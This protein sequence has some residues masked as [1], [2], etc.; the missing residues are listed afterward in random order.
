[1]EVAS[2]LFIYFLYLTGIVDFL[3]GFIISEVGRLPISIG[4]IY[5]LLFLIVI[6]WIA[7]KNRIDVIKGFFYSILFY[8]TATTLFTTFEHGNI[9][10]LIN[11]LINVSKLFL[12]LGIIV[13]GKNLLN[14]GKININV[15]KR[16]ITFNTRF[17]TISLIICKMFNLGEYAYI[18]EVG[19]KG[20]FYSNNELSIVLSLMFIYYW[21]DIYYVII[22]IKKIK[23]SNCL[24]IGLVTISMILIGAKTSYI[25]IIFTILISIIRI[26]K[27]CNVITILKGAFIICCMITI[28]FIIFNIYSQE[29]NSILE[30]QI[31]YFKENDLLSFILSD[32]NLM[33]SQIK[34]NFILGSGVFKYLF[35]F[36]GEVINNTTFINIEMD[37]NVIYLNY[38]VIGLFLIIM[39]YIYIFK[40]SPKKYIYI[41]P[42]VVYIMFSI[43]AGHVLFGAFS[44]TFLALH[45]I[46]MFQNNEYKR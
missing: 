16:I 15:I 45:C 14:I 34:N 21:E 8:F 18:N 44:G 25:I 10:A 4:Q 24:D 43:T 22:G 39:L 38:G 12:V 23:I 30:K 46:R 20:Y 3:N 13:A 2:K 35:G 9:I 42:F 28:I 5:R 36:R 37:G 26:F 17:I 11:D 31:Y 33:W 41:Y 27:H 32:R 19:F 6:I 40:N 29:I 1:M 7:I